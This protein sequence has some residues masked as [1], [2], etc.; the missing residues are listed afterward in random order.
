M[1]VTF[2]PG[3]TAEGNVSAKV[4]AAIANTSAPSLASEVNAASSVDVS[5]F[6][7]AGSFNPGSEQGRGT[8]RRLGSKQT[9]QKLGRE[10][11]TIED[12]RYVYY[13]QS[14]SPDPNNKAYETLVSGYAAF[15]VVRYGLDAQT[16]AFAV[17]QK[18]DIWPVQFGVQRKDAPP[19]DDEFALLTVTQ[20]IAV[21][22][23]VARDKAIVA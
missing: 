6:L 4:V 10:N 17:G 16:Q 3:L 8:N 22:G 23:L 18:V 9:F 5:G 13:P 11:P 21:T 1:T 14:T 2:P 20:A 15:I 7:M 12:I 19:E